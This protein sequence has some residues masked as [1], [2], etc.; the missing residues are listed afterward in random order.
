MASFQLLQSDVPT[1]QSQGSAGK[2]VL[3]GQ[4]QHTPT[5]RQSL[6]VEAQPNKVYRLVNAQDQSLVK[7]Q[8]LLR[9]GKA[10]VIEVEGAEV[11]NLQGFFDQPATPP[12]TAKAAASANLEAK[13]G[14]QYVFEAELPN[15]AYGLVEASSGSGT[16]GLIWAPGMAVPASASPV[17]FGLTPLAALGGAGGVATGT[18]LAGTVVA[19][20]AVN[21]T[22]N[23]TSTTASKDN[24]VEGKATFGDA[25]KDN[26]LLVDAYAI[27]KDGKST[28]LK[29]G[30][31]VD[32]T[33]TFR[34]NVG[35]YNGAIRL[36]IRSKGD[37]PDYTDE[38]TGKAVNLSTT[39]MA[40]AVVSGSSAAI[41]VNLTP[42]THL[43][44][45]ANTTPTVDNI[46]KVNQ[47]VGKAFGVDDIL[48]TPVIATTNQQFT[49]S[50]ST[51]GKAYGAVL[52]ALS[53]LDTQTQSTKATLET[54][55]KTLSITTDSNGATT[56]SL[57]DLGKAKL[58]D[59]AKVADEQTSADLTSQIISLVKA[60]PQADA[61]TKIAAYA[62]SKANATPE[63]SDYTTAGVTGVNGANLAAINTKVDAAT[64]TTADDLTEVQKLVNAVNKSLTQIAL[65]ANTIDENSVVG[66]GV[67]VGTFSVNDPDANSNT[68]L[69]LN[70][71]GTDAASF[72]LDGNKLI[73]KGSALDFEI[74]STYNI[75]I[76][77]TDG[78]V[79]QTQ[80]FTINVSDVNDNTP[81]ITS[82]ATNEV[83]ENLAA[84]SAIYTA[85]GTDADGTPANQAVVYSLKESTGDAA[86][87]NIDAKTGTVSLKSGSTNFEGKASYTFTV[88]ATNAGTGATLTAE[89]AVRVSVTDVNEAPTISAN[90]K[91]FSV[92]GGGQTVTLVATDLDDAVL[93]VDEKYWTGQNAGGNLTISTD[94]KLT[95]A[96]FNF[97]NGT[98][99]TQ[100]LSATV[101]DRSTGGLSDSATISVSIKPFAVFRGDIQIG[102]FDT[103]QA[104][105]DAAQEGQTVKIAAGNYL[106]QSE[107]QITK[108]IH[109]AGMDGDLTDTS[110]SVVI[111]N[112]EG[113]RS[114]V[115]ASSIAGT[116]S[117]SGIH[118]KGGSA[119]I[120][121]DGSSQDTDLSGLDI[122]NSTFTGQQNAGL[123]IN[124]KNPES[125][126]GRL[127]VSGAVFDQS[128]VTSQNKVGHDASGIQMLGFDGQATLSDVNFK[129]GTTKSFLDSPRYGIQIQ[130]GSYES[131]S[132]SATY[133]LAGGEKGSVQ[134]TDIKVEGDFSIAGIAVNNYKDISG[135]SGSNVD[136]RGAT[137]RPFKSLVEVFDIGS[138]FSLKEWG[139]QLN[140]D[141]FVALGADLNAPG[142]R[143][144]GT[145]VNDNMGGSSNNDTLFGQQGNDFL[146]GGKGDDQL[147]GGEGTD[148]A[149]YFSSMPTAFSFDDE[150]GLMTLV[151]EDGKD[152]LNGVERVINFTPGPTSNIAIATSTYVMLPFLDISEDS[153]ERL[154]Q[155]ETLI[156][157]GN[158][159]VRGGS[160]LISLPEA[161][162]ILTKGAK[163]WSGDNIT[164]QLTKNDLTSATDLQALRQMGVDTFKML[165][166]NDE[167]LNKA[168]YEAILAAMTIIGEAPEDT[169]RA[170]EAATDLVAPTVT[171]VADATP[172]AVTNTPISFTVTFD[173]AVVGTVSTSSFTAT[174]GEV[175]SVTKVNGA[176]A[177][178]V[179]VT[180][181]SGVA[182]GSVAL[183][184]VGAGLQDAAGNAVANADLSGK[185]SQ[186]IDTLAPTVTTVADTTSDAVTNA[187]ISFTVTFDEAVV[188]TV[189]TSSFTATNGTVSSVAKVA[190]A[191]AYTVVVTPTSGVASGNVALSLV[192]DGLQD[193][194]GNAVANADLSGKASQAIDTLAP[195]VT[196]TAV[197]DTNDNPDG[198]YNEGFTVTTGAT[199]IVT[200][201]GTAVTLLD[202]FTKTTAGGLDTYTAK[203]IKFT[204]TEAIT[205]D[206][207]LSDSAGNTGSATQLDLGKVDTTAPTVTLTAV[208]DTNDNPDGG[209]NQGFTV[210]A[211]ANVI[212][213]V[214]GTAVTLLDYFDLV[215]GANG[216]TDTYTAKA[217][218]FTGTEFITVD[219]SLSD[220]A[221][222][223]GNATQ[224]DLGKVDTTAPTVTLTAV[225]D[226]NDNP[227][228]GFNQGFTVT[229]GASGTVTVDGTAVTLLDFFTKT[230]A[231]GLDTYTAKA[232]KFTGTEAITVDAS[233][234]D[235]AGNTGNATQLDLGKVDTTADEGNDLAIQ[236]L[237]D[238]DVFAGT[239][240]FTL[241]GMD[242]DL[243]GASPE[244][245][246]SD[247]TNPPVVA[248]LNDGLWSADVSQLNAGALTIAVV[249]TD[250]AGNTAQT[251]H[252]V[253]TSIADAL[254]AATEKGTLKLAAGNY[255]LQ[256]E[257]QITKAITI[258]GVDG[259]AN[260]AS[261]G[262]VITNT[263]GTRSFVV[264]SS[265]AGTVSISGIKVQGGTEAVSVDGSTQDTDLFGLSITNSTFAGQQ[266]AGL[267]IGL[268]N[269]ASSLGTLN[270]S[271]VVFDQSA[272]NL[273]QNN[274]G[275]AAA[276]IMMFGFDGAATLS[277]V[278]VKGGATATTNA[279]WYG[280]H[281][282][283]AENKQLSGSSP[284][285]SSHP[286]AGSGPSL[287]GGPS[288]GTIDL[289]DVKVEG[290]FYKS[291]IAVYN[292]SDIAGISGSNVD[293]TAAASLW[294]QVLTVDGIE[295]AYSV[296]GWG[297]KLESTQFTLIGGEA[298]AQGAADSVITGS[299]GN[300]RLLGG[301]GGNDM[302]DGGDGNDFLI[303]GLGNDELDGG[304]GLDAA[305]LFSSPTAFAFDAAT[306][307]MSMTSP[308][309]SDTLLGI[310]Q[311]L[312]VNG[313]QQVL[314]R[315]WMTPF[316]GLSEDQTERT[317]Q[318]TNALQTDDVVV[319]GGIKNITLEDALTVST[320]KA[321][322]WAEDTVTVTHA[323]GSGPTEDQMT[324]LRA[325]GVDNFS[326]LSA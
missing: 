261:Q 156:N 289:S 136:L 245:T 155:I 127:N 285:D 143:I 233:L 116:V 272:A 3:L 310:E 170:L 316:M 169:T 166:P 254:Q 150:T 65:S 144:D 56:G 32:S 234:S 190:G 15:N 187:P 277:K 90:S 30:A 216:N 206:A 302:L 220:A 295:A 77:S 17:A 43:A 201:D 296:A 294:G 101:A 98:S 36:E 183:S 241:A 26:D 46:A 75:T 2:D 19:A 232:D 182:S 188:G 258:E 186:A 223:T 157:S 317:T 52:A 293:L 262:V 312:R 221:G 162:A 179:V 88:V 87:L 33:G 148:T 163:F 111:T 110:Q 324:T 255:N 123:V 42:L 298:T 248:T 185:A 243:D 305:V 225:G 109:I 226:T 228:G 168:E 13:T 176:N 40:L 236:T 79:I 1:A 160:L 203:T 14:A 93:P 60:T 24:I 104:A 35:S 313:S 122:T 139:L 83:N 193:A 58:L 6:A 173:E 50:T 119:A 134:L 131:T 281:I 45:L 67:Q 195:T 260:D 59:G 279:P 49:T 326:V 319:F 280:I 287:A 128:S 124:L 267:V 198:V 246:V 108:A 34:I 153:T 63:A 103:L 8:R 133:S 208:G 96:P 265:V 311:V 16:S 300:D 290:G 29:A 184:L 231:G 164:L 306:S 28:L 72:A 57:N 257:I 99:T 132:S 76:T 39:I 275:Q 209:F 244:V 204:G 191:N 229:E 264:G 276:G 84:G 315:Y 94:G 301:A 140:S 80:E 321:S 48:A 82:A 159:L 200:V 100:T 282:Q 250:K 308:E 71:G 270:V 73:F 199:V 18:V 167:V 51:A 25:L 174:N 278:T 102:V 222:N 120:T 210:T 64:K 239:V 146:Y 61:L 149:A 85:T 284:H 145:T 70:L 22:N 249:I 181:T 304:D 135:V 129:G 320:E 212:V 21:A 251:S 224:L 213:T 196:L 20:A 172:E 269:P 235:S 92:W 325:I 240:S 78:D 138:S 322:F 253:Y 217:D 105:I 130:G 227:D 323:D 161:R 9:K 74:K 10:L 66:T 263:G 126:L 91:T 38:A 175:T 237:D 303:G 207:S 31:E 202:F 121:V 113:T 118:V 147:D 297:L 62:D 23:K 318:L 215:A 152:V 154:D 309:G 165:S 238:A 242:S 142:I 291:G 107:I 117:F 252:T 286:W 271:G 125:S 192:G 106:L 171:T 4:V 314:A 307:T 151:S 180:P 137:S 177:Y 54:I 55:A 218:K 53:G 197:G 115:V 292:Y 273:S 247:G 47:A 11:A 141:Q 274:D 27:D 268:N 266:N 95:V 256:S 158:I 37:A 219:A 214:D 5:S 44:Y 41:T 97:Q 211:G 288:S 178:T 299:A 230:T 81:V 114:F 112:S 194:A 259:D 69:T 189:T 86:L 89:K 68:G 283:G 7:G 12:S 205:V